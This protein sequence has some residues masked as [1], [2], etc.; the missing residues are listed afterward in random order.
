MNQ[1]SAKR[2]RKHV[3]ARNPGLF[4]LLREEYGEEVLQETQDQIYKKAKRLYKKSPFL[5]NNILK[6]GMDVVRKEIEKEKLNEPT[7]T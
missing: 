4:L 6:L 2:I 3:R 7:S 1:K 5:Q